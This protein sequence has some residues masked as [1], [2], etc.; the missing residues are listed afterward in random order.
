M[1]AL[2]GSGVALITPFNED[3]TLDI[4]SL[5][6]LIEYQITGGIDYIV[7][8]GTTGETA[9]LNKKEKQEI[10]K[11]IAE[12]VNGRVPL[13]AGIGGNNTK[14]ILDEFDYFDLTGYSAILS[15][16]P[17]YNRPTQ[18]GL[19]Q[20]YKAIAEASPLPIILYNV[21]ARTGSNIQAETTVRLAN[22]FKNIIGIKEASGNFHQYST[23]IRDTPA[24]FFL[25]S[26]DDALLLPMAALGASGVISVLANALPTQV[27]RLAKMCNENNFEEARKI[28]TMLSKIIDLCFIEGNPAGVKAILKQ[29]GICGEKTRLPLTSVSDET[30]N[31]IIRELKNL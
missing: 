13:I 24:G 3:D 28:H 15:V 11:T 14:D 27:S 12:K 21:P 23:I 19:F 29:L 2:T 31:N 18:E 5:D 10:F 9:T 7:V 20:H 25:I 17:Y 30:R 8:L 16:S 1:K 6:K 26:G 22:T 4:P